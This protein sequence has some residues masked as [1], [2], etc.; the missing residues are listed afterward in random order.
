[1]ALFPIFLVDSE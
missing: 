1:M